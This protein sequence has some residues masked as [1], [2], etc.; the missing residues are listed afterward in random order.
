M[1][2]KKRRVTV[3]SPTTDD[4][5]ESTDTAVLL[6]VCCD[7]VASCVAAA[8]GG[9]HR[10]ELCTGLVDG[11]VT[12]SIGLIRAAVA[13]TPLPV[14]VLIRPRGG[15][16]VY[17][18]AE[19]SV[20]QYDIAQASLVGA[21]GVVIGA[22]TAEGDMDV[23]TVKSLL[24]TAKKSGMSCT[25]HR[26]VQCRVCACVCVCVCASVVCVYMYIPMQTAFNSCHSC[27]EHGHPL[28]GETVANVRDTHTDV[29]CCLRC[30]AIDM[31]RDPLA[32]VQACMD[33]GIDRILTSGGSNDAVRM[34]SASAV[35]SLIVWFL[36]TIVESVATR[37]E[38]D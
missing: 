17:S 10:I 12:P 34:S 29:S 28:C 22:L 19:V 3:D 13:A 26:W 16:F 1:P 18:E 27:R 37:Y 5:Q 7:S 8:Q 25:F 33:C 2:P 20:M 6:E 38:T 31:A 15:D 11:G 23:K 36:L 32:V 4:T 9:A 30:S 35:P 21:K 14:M 24:Q